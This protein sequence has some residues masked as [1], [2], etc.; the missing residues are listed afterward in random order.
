MGLKYPNQLSTI[1]YGFGP[2]KKAKMP[3]MFFL[4]TP[5]F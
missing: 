4:V 3:F 1:S 5:D 2:L